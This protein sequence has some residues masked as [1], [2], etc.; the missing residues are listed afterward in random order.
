MSFTLEEIKILR[1]IL[2][3]ALA[4]TEPDEQDRAT[5]V[6]QAATNAVKQIDKIIVEKFLS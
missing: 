3:D 1:K 2:T 4:S 6:S 5:D